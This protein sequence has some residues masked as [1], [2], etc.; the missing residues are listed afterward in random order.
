MTDVMAPLERARERLRRIFSCSYIPIEPEER[1]ALFE[2]YRSTGASLDEWLEQAV[3]W[4]N[5][6]LIKFLLERRVIPSIGTMKMAVERAP[7]EI[8]EILAKGGG[9]LTF[10]ML[11]E[12]VMAPDRFRCHVLSLLQHALQQDAFEIDPRASDQ[13]LGAAIDYG[14]ADEVVKL[15][16]EGYG[17]STNVLCRDGSP[18]LH[19]CRSQN[20]ELAAFLID[21]GADYDFHR[22]KCWAARTFAKRYKRSMPQTWSR[23]AKRE[24][25]LKA[26]KTRKRMD[27]PV[28]LRRAM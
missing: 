3:A 9:E 6:E 1:A 24:L 21:S 11:F 7:A 4:S 18:L 13:L 5:T 15:L 17:A 22:P 27:A 14:N 2:H 28:T 23:V 19:A 25:S 16:V 10:S 8:V 26:A 20:D 12:M